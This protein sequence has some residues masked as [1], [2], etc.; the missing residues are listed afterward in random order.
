MPGVSG[1]EVAEQIRGQ[2]SGIAEMSLLAYSSSVEHGSS[3]S[4]EAG[5]NG[6]IIKPASRKKLME[7]VAR[8][9]GAKRGSPAKSE[10]HT[11]ISPSHPDASNNG[12]LRILLAE[13][14]PA[15]VK[16][17][18]LVL[19]KAGFRVDVA[20]NGH[21]AVAKYTSSPGTFDLILM[22]VQMPEMDGL[23][24]TKA[25]RE[26]GFDTIPIIAMT[27]NAMKGDRENCLD[28]GMNDYIPKPIRREN[29]LEV[30]RKWT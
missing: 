7:V 5:F 28:A 3:S 11:V 25:I 2:K 27:A 20:R 10:E 17:T 24:A 22:D 6:F 12:G 19:A 9:I 14:N 26:K 21:E 1:Y 18:T 13:D 8:L 29:V 4:I 15:N 23:K 16:L 30:I